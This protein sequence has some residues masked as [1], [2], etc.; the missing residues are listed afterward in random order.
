MNE[1][2]SSAATYF[3]AAIKCNHIATLVGK[4]AG[5]PLISN[6]DVTR[7]RLP[8]TELACYSS[9]STYYLPCAE[10][11]NE[12]VKPDY[13]VIPNIEDL[14]HDTDKYLEYTLEL[15]HKKK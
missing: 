11:R 15:I 5:Q 4:E 8:N 3:V 13:E 1:K 12:S 2:T 10:N 7:F 6:G 9:M 14:L